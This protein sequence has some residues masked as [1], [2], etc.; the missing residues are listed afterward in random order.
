MDWMEMS[1]RDFQSALASSSPT[2]GGGTASAVALGQAAALT[3]MVADL[4]IGK[5]KW[6]E[7]WVCAEKAQSI[8]IKIFSQAGKLA[9][10]DSDSF[11]LVMESFKLPKSNE[12]EIQSRR[13]AIRNATLKAALVPFETAELAYELLEVLPELANKGNANAVSDVGVASLLASA[14]A[15]GALFNVDINL[16]SLPEEMIGDLGVKS[17]QLLE[18]S[19][20][21]SKDSLNV[22][23]SRLN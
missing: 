3:C 4:T 2:P 7:G 5:E 8:A 13:N 22:V 18:K 12:E 23:R 17:A 1:L 14:A 21:L 6:K 20:L 9:K 19:R 11:D 16:G 10:D 15:K